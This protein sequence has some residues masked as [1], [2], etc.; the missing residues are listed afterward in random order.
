VSTPP[1]G[2]SYCSQSTAS[3]AI[4]HAKDCEC[5]SCSLISDERAPMG[6]V[7]ATS[8]SVRPPLTNTKS[9]M[10]R[11]LMRSARA[12]GKGKYD[13]L[14]P[15][16][17]RLFSV[18]FNQ[19]SAAPGTNSVNGSITLTTGNFPELASF[20]AVYDEMRLVQGRLH[21]YVSVAGTGGGTG[22]G[23]HSTS[24]LFDQTAGTPLSVNGV[25]EETFSQGP[26]P[27]A[28]VASN[29]A[30]NN[31]KMRC[32][33]FHPPTSTAPIGTNVNP[34]KAWFVL[35]SVNAPHMVQVNHFC[36]SCAGT[37]ATTFVYY[38]ELDVELRMRT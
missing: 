17:V 22:L 15:I 11:Q 19:S 2:L 9:T 32:L 12:A 27:I 5:D 31:T 26:Y 37:A 28:S 8:S 4:K 10:L 23:F 30:L 36:T 24:V 21:Y 20:L 38:V 7:V 25:L 18:Q 6:Q 16:R 34:G 35:D 33:Q 29:Y 3:A 1:G 14:K 13:G